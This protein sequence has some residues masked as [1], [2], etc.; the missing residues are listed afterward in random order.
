MEQFKPFLD[1]YTNE[2]TKK[3]YTSI[4]KR[5]LDNNVDIFNEDEVITFIGTLKTDNTKRNYMKCVSAILRFNKVEDEDRGNLIENMKKLNERVAVNNS[6]KEY[7]FI[8]TLK[9]LKQKW[10]NIKNLE[11]KCIFSLYINEP[12]LRADFVKIN[13]ENYN[14]GVLKIKMNKTENERTI[15][16][17]KITTDLLNKYFE[18]ND[19]FNI[20]LKSFYT[21]SLKYFGEKL[22]INNFR[23]IYIYENIKKIQNNKKITELTRERKIQELG[24]SMD[25]S[26][27]MIRSYYLAR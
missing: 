11:H 9:S 4:I 12:P 18:D 19:S 2:I 22:T 3:T 24:K 15:K 17:S 14:D 21:L 10:K 7:T 16:F 13:N 25:S 20:S 26:A 8:N 27:N 5:F 1:S 23:H 6:E